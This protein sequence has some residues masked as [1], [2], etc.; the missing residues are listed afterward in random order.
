[1][2]GLGWFGSHLPLLERFVDGVGSK[3]GGLLKLRGISGLRLRVLGWGVFDFLE[4]GV[5]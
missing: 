2:S 3:G 5:L 4:T 1:M